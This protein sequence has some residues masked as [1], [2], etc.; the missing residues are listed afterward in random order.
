M[1]TAASAAPAGAA[2]TPASRKQRTIG[3]ATMHRVHEPLAEEMGTFSRPGLHSSWWTDRRL[4]G[5]RPRPA[6][7]GW[8]ATGTTDSPKAPAAAPAPASQQGA[9]HDGQ[10]SSRKI[11]CSRGR[12]GGGGG[13]EQEGGRGWRALNWACSVDWQLGNSRLTAHLGNDRY[14]GRRIAF[15]P[16]DTVQRSRTN[17][18]TVGKR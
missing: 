13:G 9:A 11:I 8:R 5:A 16:A 3:P 15:H 2:L 10:H 12:G 1:W 17:Y 14:P 18:G 4:C 7:R 6:H